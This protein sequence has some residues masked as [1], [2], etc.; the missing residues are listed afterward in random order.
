MAQN[1]KQR[2]MTNS[3]LETFISNLLDFPS[4]YVY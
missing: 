1:K 3:H 4:K 2:G